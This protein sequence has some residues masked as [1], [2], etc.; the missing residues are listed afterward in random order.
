MICRCKKTICVVFCLVVFICIISS[1]CIYIS[2]NEKTITGE[3]H[4]EEKEFYEL[5]DLDMDRISGI[6]VK[7]LGVEVELTQEYKNDILECFDLAKSNIRMKD[8]PFRPSEYT[9]SIELSGERI[10]LP[11]CWFNGKIYEED[12]IEYI[13]RRFDVYSNG[14]WY[15]YL[16]NDT[17]FWNEDKLESAFE[18]CCKQSNIHIP[19]RYKLEGY[20]KTFDLSNQGRE[21]AKYNVSEI[22][23]EEIL[24][25][26]EYVVAGTSL[27]YD[28]WIESEDENVLLS[29]NVFKF[30][31]DESYKGNLQNE[32][33]TI[34][35][36]FGVS[37]T[38]GKST[39]RYPFVEN[40]D[41]IEG[42]TYLL[43]LDDCPVGGHYNITDEF[44]GCGIIHEGIT[45]PRYNT[46]NHPFYKVNLEEI[47]EYCS[48]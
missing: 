33:I 28:E 13:D 27:G 32:V 20:D 36:L 15:S 40:P 10:I 4:I 18:E 16:Q 14:F 29:K 24:N 17:I 45:Y 11:I 47:R 34:L 37:Y 35:P 5:L 25:T 44:A 38:N 42:E 21:S 3:E 8:S 31:I 23:L 43:C 39:I 30:R 22:G 1:E 41:L 12:S 26:A 19:D 7:Y 48:K 6:Y 9:L 46:E 2:E